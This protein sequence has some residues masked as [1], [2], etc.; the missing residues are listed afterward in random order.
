VFEVVDVEPDFNV[1]QWG[2]YPLQ[3]HFVVQAQAGI[4]RPLIDGVEQFLIR[5]LENI[6]Q[7]PFAVGH[8]LPVQFA[9]GDQLRQGVGVDDRI[10]LHGFG[11]FFR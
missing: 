6:F 9:T 4:Q 3:L 7:H 11:V 8:F 1:Q 10:L 2:A 5:G